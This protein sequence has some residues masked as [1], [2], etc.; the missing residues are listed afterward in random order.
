MAASIHV[1]VLLYHHVNAHPSATTTAPQTFRAHLQWLAEQG[2]RSLTLDE[3]EAAVA[4]RAAVGPR[5]FLLT[6]DDGSPDLSHCAVEMEAFGFTGVAF[7]ITGRVQQGDP[8]CIA[9][10]E[11]VRLAGRGTLEFQS[12]THRHVRVGASAEEME[13]LAADLAASH[14]WLTSTLGR[15]PDA[16]RHLAWPWGRCTPAMETLAR[17]AGFD[18]QYLVQRGSVTH[19]S[20]QLRLPRLCADGMPTAQFAKWMTLMASRPGGMLTN[21]VFGAIRRMRHGMAYW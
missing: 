1:P 14:A 3:F 13:A 19:V 6:Y 15:S 20:T 2:W 5:R 18:W 4:G 16:V 8:D 9:T 12:H 11:V 17:E 21:Y 10:D 7:L